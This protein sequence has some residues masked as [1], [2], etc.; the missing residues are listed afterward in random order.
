MRGESW[1]GPPPVASSGLPGGTAKG[2]PAPAREVTKRSLSSGAMAK[3]GWWGCHQHPA[4]ASASWATWS[5]CS[6]RK[7]S[8]SQSRPAH[9]CHRHLASQPHESRADDSH[10]RLTTFS[11]HAHAHNPPVWHAATHD[12]LHKIRCRTPPHMLLP[13]LRCM[14]RHP[15]KIKYGVDGIT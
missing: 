11:T 1:K 13:F 8:K 2:P 9:A 6:P 14:C 7:T 12:P 10:L 5:A 15:C 3:P 4:A